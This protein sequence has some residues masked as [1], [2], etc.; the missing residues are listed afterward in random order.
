MVFPWEHLHVALVPLAEA[1]ADQAVVLLA[2]EARSESALVV[3]AVP[4]APAVPVDLVVQEDAVP[5][6]PVGSCQRPVMVA[7]ASQEEAAVETAASD[8]SVAVVAPEAEEEDLVELRA[9]LAAA[10]P[11]LAEGPA[12]AAQR[13]ALV[14]F[15]SVP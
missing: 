1:V 8:A 2:P 15:P 9:A 11:A 5:A 3:Q 7:A 12:A 6:D 10:V 13:L 4:E 14:E